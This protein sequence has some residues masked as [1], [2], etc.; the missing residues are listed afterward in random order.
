[1]VLSL[2]I[3]DRYAIGH[4]PDDIAADMKLSTALMRYRDG[5]FSIGAACE[6]CGKDIYAF[7]EECARH[8]I[9]VI[10]YDENDLEREIRF[11][12]QGKP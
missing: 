4:K 12:A 10:D 1:M 6:F 3:P 7:I 9:D 8:D 5:E 2:E 11:F